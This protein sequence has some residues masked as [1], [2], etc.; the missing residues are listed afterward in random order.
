M[1]LESTYAREP[2]ICFLYFC[3]IFQLKSYHLLRNAIGNTSLG[4][5]I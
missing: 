2:S 4:L 3:S 1:K 5:A